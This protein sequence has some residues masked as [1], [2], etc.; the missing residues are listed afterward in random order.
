MAFIERTAY[1]RFSRVFTQCE[2]ENAFTPTVDEVLVARMNTR[3]STGLFAIL[4]WCAGVVL[5][6]AIMA[7]AVQFLLR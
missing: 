4:A 5:F 6:S 3:N 2:L 7:F 1:P